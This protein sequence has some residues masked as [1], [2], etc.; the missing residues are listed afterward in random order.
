MLCCMQGAVVMPL[1]KRG[2]SMGLI[3]FVLI[4]ARKPE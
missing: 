2:F 1:M 3:K 4:T